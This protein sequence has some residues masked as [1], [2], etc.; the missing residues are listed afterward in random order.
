MLTSEGVELK[1]GVEITKVEQQGGRKVCHYTEKT[2]GATGEVIGSEILVAAG[3][4]ANVEGLGLETVGIHADA[5]HGIEVDECL[6]THSARVFAVG[7]VLLRHPSAGAAVREADVVLQNAVLRLKKKIDYSGVP[8]GAFTDPEVASVGVTA[9]T[10]RARALPSRVYRLDFSQV[11]RAVIDGRT[12]GFAKVVVTP[13]GKVLGAT[14]VGEDAC[15]ILQEFVLAVE[16]GLGLRDLAA[17]T[18]IYPT[19]AA[20]AGQ[21]AEEHRV[22][23][24]ETGLFSKALRLFYGFAPRG[25]TGNGATARPT[26]EQESPQPA[27]PPAHEHGH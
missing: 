13:S 26:A 17:A 10:A 22:T 14:V 15:M 3:R 23:R 9:A 8:A 4:L 21:L 1:L 12:D 7:D 18:P 6:Q 16:R 25:T 19:Y 20:I 24:L 5:Q 11:D 2:T 27:E